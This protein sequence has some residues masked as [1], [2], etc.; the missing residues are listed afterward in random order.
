MMIIPIS[1]YIDDVVNINKLTGNLTSV[2]TYD[3]TNDM[4]YYHLS[5]SVLTIVNPL[6]GYDFNIST[7]AIILLNLSK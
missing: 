2:S 4:F 3:T 6:T 7:H 5:Q 1:N